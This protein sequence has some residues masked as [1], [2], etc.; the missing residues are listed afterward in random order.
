V[1]TQTHSGTKPNH[2]ASASGEDVGNGERT[3]LTPV[4]LVIRDPD[5]ENTFVVDGE[6]ETIDVDLGRGFDGPKGFRALSDEEQRE[7][8]ESTI[9]K[10]AH[11]P[12]DSNVRKAVEEFVEEFAS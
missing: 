11:L 5:Y 1:N 9:A 8:I 10:V 6:V 12:V 4:V 3:K 2:P 7:W